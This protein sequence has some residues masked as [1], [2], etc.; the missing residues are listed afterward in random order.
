MQSYAYILKIQISIIMEIVRL[1]IFISA[2]R[3]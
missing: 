1:V 2:E 3:T